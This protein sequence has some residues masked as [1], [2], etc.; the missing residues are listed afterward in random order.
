M[1]TTFEGKVLWSH[2]DANMHMRHSAYADFG[3]QARIEA[4]SE[5]G[6][7]MELYN[8]H[9]IGPIL[10]REE[11]IY[12]REVGMND[13]L[14]V[15]TELTKFNSEKLR[16]SIKNEI[17]RSDGVKAATIH[18]DGAWIDMKTRKLAQSLPEEVMKCFLSLTKSEDFQML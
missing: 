16:Y 13:V 8:K 9:K 12:H 10:F 5:S 7:N 18:V 2:I 11:L 3:A 1:T 6:I 4:F 15:T 14:K 17:F